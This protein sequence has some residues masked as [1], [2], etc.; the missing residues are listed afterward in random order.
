MPHLREAIDAGSPEQRRRVLEALWRI[1]ADG[2]S[3]EAIVRELEHA[4]SDPD[5][6]I[7]ERAELALADLNRLTAL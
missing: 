5:R 2:H 1:A 4:R 7:A 6:E 3:T